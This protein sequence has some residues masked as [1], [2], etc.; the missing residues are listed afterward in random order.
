M[1][2]LLAKV[3]DN[4]IYVIKGEQAIDIKEIGTDEPISMLSNIYLPSTERH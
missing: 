4:Y 3:Y 2:L 1:F